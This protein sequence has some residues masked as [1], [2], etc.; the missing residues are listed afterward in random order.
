MFIANRKLYT[1]CEVESNFKF[2]QFISYTLYGDEQRFLYS[3]KPLL[4]VENNS[5]VFIGLE[6]WMKSSYPFGSCPNLKLSHHRG[7]LNENIPQYNVH[8]SYIE[9][10]YTTL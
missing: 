3:V 7:I 9:N 1:L 5:R 8:W 6:L 4:F 2:V 10:T